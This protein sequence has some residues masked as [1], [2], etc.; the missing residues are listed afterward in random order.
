MEF[1]ETH[2]SVGT[3]RHSKNTSRDV[4]KVLCETARKG[5][6]STMFSLTGMRIG[7]DAR[8]LKLI[9]TVPLGFPT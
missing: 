7:W 6:A 8:I 4:F 1:N 3:S 9:S 5:M 2:P